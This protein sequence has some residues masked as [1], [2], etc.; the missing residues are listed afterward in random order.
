MENNKDM[1]EKDYNPQ[2]HTVEHL[3]NGLISK[4]VGCSRAFSTHIERKKSKL[5]YKFTR[6]LTPE[7]ILEL[8]HDVNAIILEDVLV[9]TVMMPIELARQKFDLSRLPEDVHESLRIVNIGDYDSCPCIGTHVSKT[10]EIGG[11]LKIIST[12]F[13]NDTFVLRVR[14]KIV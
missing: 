10:S 6:N 3:L 12:D 5:D 13:N 8:E 14:F 2:M 9:D 7:E 11:N 4:K 1:S